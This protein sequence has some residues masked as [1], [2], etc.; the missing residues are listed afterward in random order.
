[1]LLYISIILDVD[2]LILKIKIPTSYILFY[3]C[4]AFCIKRKTIS[5]KFTL[6]IPYFPG[7]KCLKVPHLVS[8]LCGGSRLC[9]LL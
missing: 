2:Y 4:I 5:K 7:G 1:M 6:V 8:A 9:P 3:V